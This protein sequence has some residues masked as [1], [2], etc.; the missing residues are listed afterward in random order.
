MGTWG[1]GISSNDTYC[2]VYEQFF[3]MYN[4][5]LEVIE[6]TNKLMEMF[7]ETIRCEEDYTNFWFALA[8]GQWECKALS[9]DV[10]EKVKAIIENEE[11][12]RIW[13]QLDANE[14]DLQARRNVLAKFLNNLSVE[15]KSPKKRKK[16][17]FKPAIF[18]KGDCIIFRMSNGN[19]GG[20]VVIYTLDTKEA[21][22]NLIVKTRIN[23][24]DK[25]SLYD[26]ELTE[27]L[28]RQLKEYE[29]GEPIT[30]ERA[31]AQWFF[32]DGYKKCAHL[33]E[34]IGRMEPAKPI[35]TKSMI[36]SGGWGLLIS[37]TEEQFSIEEGR[38]VPEKN[39]RLMDFI[40]G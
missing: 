17:R 24:A 35:E 18:E 21:G 31:D 26:F 3:S 27:V 29:D 4:E 6:I 14:K 23:Q 38:N 13:K 30:K 10:F 9:P 11:D 15:K 7:D 8:K 32:P 12:I 36:I 25:P 39:E 37:Q 2:E 28:I 33:F 34:V 19:F 22:L 1:T 20:A 5:G 40:K 16:T